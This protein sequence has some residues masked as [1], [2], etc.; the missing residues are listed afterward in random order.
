MNVERSR[1]IPR[2]GERIGQVE[3]SATTA[4]VEELLVVN[5]TKNVRWVSL[6]LSLS[7]CVCVCDIDVNVNAIISC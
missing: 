3:A 2:A 1:Y 6:S 4:T 5:N 7:V